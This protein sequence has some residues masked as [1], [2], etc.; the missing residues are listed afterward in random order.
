[1]YI[2]RLMIPDMTSGEGAPT[3]GVQDAAARLRLAFAS[4]ALPVT[5]FRDLLYQV[6]DGNS[7]VIAGVA[8]TMPAAVPRAPGPGVRRLLPVD[9]GT[10][11]RLAAIAD[12]AERCRRAAVE[13]AAA[14]REQKTAQQLRL[15]ALV[16][17][18]VRYGG[19]QA[20]CYR[21]YGIIRHVY[22]KALRQS[23]VTLPDF[24]GPEATF[25]EAAYW[26]R[27]YQAARARAQTA[28]LVRDAEIRALRSGRY[29]T[30]VTGTELARLTGHS[31]ALIAQKAPAPGPA[32]APC[33]A[34]GPAR[35]N[36]SGRGIPAPPGS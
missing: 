31:T 35:G 19:T 1:M 33:Q 13:T 9:T 10:L 30:E 22:E 14:T 7:D 23:P 4:G 6:L 5:S 20:S 8:G 11:A 36:M 18:H 29:G 3:A 26:D 17:A 32:G 16:T 27:E 24:G 2:G 28:R 12:P 25:S 21:P 34:G 15:Q